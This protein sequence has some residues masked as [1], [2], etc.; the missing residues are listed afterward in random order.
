MIWIQLI[1]QSD[2]P[3]HQCLGSRHRKPK[4]IIPCMFYTPDTRQEGQQKNYRTDQTQQLTGQGHC[5]TDR[6]VFSCT[7]VTCFMDDEGG[8][9]KQSQYQNDAQK[10]GANPF[11]MTHAF[12]LLP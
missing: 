7:I 11:L 4:G 3:T 6:A 2:L 10:P 5:L 1:I 12:F 9:N 8:R